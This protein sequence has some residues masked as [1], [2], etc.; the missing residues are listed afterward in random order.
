MCRGSRSEFEKL[1]AASIEPEIK[2]EP[3]IIAPIEEDEH[4]PK[5]R[6]NRV[7]CLARLIV[8]KLDAEQYELVEE[9]LFK[10][11][12]EARNDRSKKAK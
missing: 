8:T 7:Q 9:L 6:Q 4:K 10:A 11:I 12:A 3:K 1:M 2:P 5:V